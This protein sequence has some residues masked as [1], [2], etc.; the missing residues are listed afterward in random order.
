[1]S[2]FLLTLLAATAP[3]TLH[4]A[5]EEAQKNDL[6]FAFVDDDNEAASWA[7]HRGLTQVMPTVDVGAQITR[8]QQ[9]IE[10]NGRV[11]T[12]L[13]FPQ[14]SAMA[15]LSLF[16]GPLIPNAIAGYMTEGAVH[17]Q[18]VERREALAHDVAIRFLALAEAQARLS[19]QSETLKR[20][21]AFVKLAQIRERLGEGVALDVDNAEAELSRLQSE[22]ALIEGERSAA[23][24][25]LR[26]V[27]APQTDTPLHVVCDACVPVAGAEIGADDDV[28]LLAQREDIAAAVQLTDA[29]L[30]REVG[31]WLT[32][33]PN[34][35]VV[36]ASRLQPPT[37]FNPNPLWW[38][39][40]LV[41]SWEVFS[42]GRTLADGLDAR[43]ATRR[44]HLDAQW[45]KRVAGNDVKTAKVALE[46]GLAVLEAARERQRAAQSALTR[47]RTAFDLGEVD[48][49]VVSEAARSLESADVALVQAQ[50]RLMR[51]RLFARRAKGLPPLDVAKRENP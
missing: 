42:G 12:P 5:I 15:R 30:V 32:F 46:G 19:A 25:R 24:I 34:V 16:R 17:Q 11:V 9:E 20:A 13:I 27:V 50:F 14:A 2:V 44:A 26:E 18:S 43:R 36:G 22:L 41:L 28:D 47:A 10:V 3:L 31:T 40:Q 37:L 39:V 35:E 7:A 4:D 29:A 21:K 51:A 33:L 8:N 48:T 38:N 6:R 45:A 49:L 23:E 1:M